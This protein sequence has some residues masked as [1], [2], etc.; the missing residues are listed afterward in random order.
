MFLSHYSDNDKLLRFKRMHY[1]ESINYTFFFG[2]S[3]PESLTQTNQS[4]HDHCF[5]SSEPLDGVT[6]Q[7]GFTWQHARGRNSEPW[8][9]SGFALIRPQSVPSAFSF[10]A[11]FLFPPSLSFLLRP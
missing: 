4:C 11:L 2:G 6:V 1:T 3:V 7:S 5:Y 9:K 8:E 10:I